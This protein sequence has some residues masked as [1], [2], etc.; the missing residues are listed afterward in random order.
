M[1]DAIDMARDAIELKCISMEDANEKIPEPSDLNQLNIADGTFLIL[2]YISFLLLSYF[3]HLT[4]L[5]ILK[6]FVTFIKS[7]TLCTNDTKEAFHYVRRTNKK[8]AD[9]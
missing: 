7:F 1:N 3:N 6:Y 2:Y 5:T 8:T 4:N 9:C